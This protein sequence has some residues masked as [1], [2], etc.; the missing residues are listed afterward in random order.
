[1][2]KCTECYGL[3]A[4]MAPVRNF[5]IIDETPSDRTLLART[6][7]RRFPSALLQDTPDAK[8]ALAWVKTRKLDAVIVHQAADADA[9]TLVRELRRTSPALP[10]LLVSAAD[11]AKEAAAAGANCFLPFDAWSRVGGVI[12]DLLPN[13]KAP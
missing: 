1:M 6:L 12:A 3:T 9:V 10:I 4:C 11:R 5:L 13:E 8:T 7:L 2:P